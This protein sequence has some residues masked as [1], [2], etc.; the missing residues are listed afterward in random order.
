MITKLDFNVRVKGHSSNVLDEVSRS[1]LR[2][3]SALGSKSRYAKRLNYQV[4]SFRGVDLKHF[5]N[6]DYFVYTTPIQGNGDTYAVTIAFP[7]V[8]SVL[9]EVIKPT[10]GDISKLNYQMVVKA[11]RLA[12]DRT[13]DVKVRCECDDFK[14]RFMYWADHYGYLYGKPTP[15]TE[16]FPEIRNPEDNLG[17]TCKHLNLFLSNKVWLQKAASSVI[18]IIRTYPEKAEM[19]LY[20]PEDIKHDTETPADETDM[21]QIPTEDT[22]DDKEINNISKDE[23]SNTEDSEDIEEEPIED[24]ENI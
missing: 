2:R 3:K 24:E 1:D 4:P 11:L 17:A 5:F 19:Y 18:N 13:D 9:K 8:L 16:K 7:G 21:A 6:N 14:Y 20:D 23:I 12:F 22:L 15:G 10:D